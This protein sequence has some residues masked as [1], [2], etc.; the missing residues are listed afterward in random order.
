MSN[1]PTVSLQTYIRSGKVQQVIEESI[2]GKNVGNFTT[3]LLSVVNSNPV[4]QEC[5]PDTVIKA[6]I[7][8]TSMNL[9]IDPNLGFAY[10]IPYNNKKKR[11]VEIKKAD[12]T[13][14]TKW[15]EYKQQEAQF[16]LGYKGFIQL[17]QR[18]GQFKRI[19]STE[20]KDG[21]YKGIDRRSGEVDFEFIEDEAERKKVKDIGY[22]AYFRLLNGFEKELYMTVEEIRAHAKKYSASYRSGYGQWVDNFDGMAKKTV[23]K[24]LISKYG[25][26]STT[27]QSALLAD[28]AA[29]EEDGYNYVDN[30]SDDT[31][32][33]NPKGDDKEPIEGEVVDDEPADDV[34]QSPKEPTEAEAPQTTLSASDSLTSEETL[35]T[36]KKLPKEG[37]KVGLKGFGKADGNY[38][39]KDAKDGTLNLEPEGTIQCPHCELKVKSEAGLKIHIGQKHKEAK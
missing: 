17:A 13:S 2:G 10:I 30:Q 6:A 38:D 27:L 18:S 9:P 32:D 11:K 26:L 39:V 35:D 19:N 36:L 8:A 23:L 33:V 29:V 4:L 16:Q 3:S 12:G 31:D 37:E 24:L 20:I 22:L 14:F 15:E 21:E 7:T 25:A 34:D 1:K 5:P 28:Q